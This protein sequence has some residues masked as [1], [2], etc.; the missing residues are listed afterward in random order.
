MFNI[1]VISF[2]IWVK[3]RVNGEKWK[4]KEKREENETKK[5]IW[6]K[7]C[8][9]KITIHCFTF[10][11]WMRFIRNWFSLNGFYELDGEMKMMGEREKWMEN[12]NNILIARSIKRKWKKKKIMCI[13]HIRSLREKWKKKT[14]SK[15]NCQRWKKIENWKKKIRIRIKKKRRKNRMRK[16]EKIKLC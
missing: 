7:L 6:K 9:M 1:Y 16:K 15:G 10:P 8:M 11:Q 2:H 4:A 14:R 12:N 3:K 5:K 13:I